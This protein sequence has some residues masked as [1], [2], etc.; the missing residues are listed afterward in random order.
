[1]IIDTTAP[2]V[3]NGTGVTERVGGVMLIAQISKLIHGGLFK[4]SASSHSASPSSQPFPTTSS[5]VSSL[6]SPPSLPTS[7]GIREVWD[8]SRTIQFDTPDVHSAMSP[9]PS[10]TSFTTCSSGTG[11][12]SQAQVLSLEEWMLEPFLKQR[13]GWTSKS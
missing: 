10:N 2:T 13:R 6:L 8:D 9:N 5:G 4:P 7:Q 3:G 1:M 11:P 12:T